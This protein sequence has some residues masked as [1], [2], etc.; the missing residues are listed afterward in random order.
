MMNCDTLLMLGTDFPYQQF[1]PKNA[2][3]V[4][5]DLREEQ[6][7]RR[8]RVDLGI[9]GGVVETLRGLLPLL[10]KRKSIAIWMP[11]SRTIV[12]PARTLTIWRQASRDK[13][14]SIRNMWQGTK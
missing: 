2:R 4:Q 13:S 10:E 7:G 14:Q 1:Y 8:S 3:I 5:V 12:R 9:A 11:R 6:L